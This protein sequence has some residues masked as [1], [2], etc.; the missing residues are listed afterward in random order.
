[1]CLTKFGQMMILIGQLLSTVL[2][3]YIRD[4]CLTKVVSEYD[5]ELP[6]SHTAEK[7]VAL[8]GTAT[9]Q[10]RDTRKPN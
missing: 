6:Q 2:V 10:S 1:M 9:Q 7:S 8:R 5:Q 4:M 3:S